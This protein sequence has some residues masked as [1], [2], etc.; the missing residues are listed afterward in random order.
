MAHSA[1]QHAKVVKAAFAQTT[2]AVPL[3][4]VR[5]YVATDSAERRVSKPLN[6]R[7]NP[8]RRVSEGSK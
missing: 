4:I 7:L 1:A 6:I 8:V 5:Q 3:V 2:S